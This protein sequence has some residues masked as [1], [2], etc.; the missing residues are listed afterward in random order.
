MNFEKTFQKIHALQL[1]LT[2]QEMAVHRDREAL[3]VATE[4][5]S[6]LC[7]QACTK[8]AKKFN[9]S[10]QM[11]IVPPEWI[12]FGLATGAK[13]IDMMSVRLKYRNNEH[14]PNGNLSDTDFRGV[15][16]RFRKILDAELRAAGIPLTVGTF[17]PS[18]GYYPR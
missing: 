18:S 9:R 6:N 15:E 8:A 4:P 7:K 16:S 11:L 17:L 5:L 3:R 14:E 1:K 13:K 10:A 2:G 12:R